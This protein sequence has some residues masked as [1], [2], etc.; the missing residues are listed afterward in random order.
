[1]TKHKAPKEETANVGSSHCPF[2]RPL[3]ASLL[4]EFNIPKSGPHKLKVGSAYIVSPLNKLAL[5]MSSPRS[6]A[7][8]CWKCTMSTPIHP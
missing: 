6:L 4:S 7:T 8:S 3:F 1:M 2:K 5:P